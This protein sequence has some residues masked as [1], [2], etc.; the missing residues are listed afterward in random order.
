MK[1]SY[2]TTKKLREEAGIMQKAGV[3]TLKDLN[4]AV[5]MVFEIQERLSL[6]RAAIAELAD[7]GSCISAS[8]ADYVLKHSS[9]L[10]K[11][12]CDI[13]DGLR[14]GEV[15]INGVNYR[16]SEMLLD[17]ERADG[18]NITAE[19][20]SKLPKSWLVK[21]ESVSWSNAK[22]DK[23]FAAKL[24]ELGLVR[25]RKYEWSRLKIEVAGE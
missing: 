2:K 9:C 18:G 8:A 4:E 24:E 5:P 7:F 15:C 1:G 23:A 25:R 11:P 21:K 17:P 16:L 13:R 20:R 3:H 19:F 14:H 22:S 12:M 10:D 6:L